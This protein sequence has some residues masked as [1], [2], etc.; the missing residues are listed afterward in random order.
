[1]EYDYA[2]V[3]KILVN[4]LNMKMFKQMKYIFL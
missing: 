4:W 2:L 1:M 3:Y